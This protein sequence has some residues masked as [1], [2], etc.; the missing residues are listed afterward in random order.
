MAWRGPRVSLLPQSKCYQAGFTVL[1]LPGQ[2]KAP[3]CKMQT[4]ARQVRASRKDM[5]D[6]E[7]LG[8]HVKGRTPGHLPRGHVGQDKLQLVKQVPKLKAKRE[9]LDETAPALV[10]TSRS[11]K[12]HW[13]WG[14]GHEITAG[15]HLPASS[16]QQAVWNSAWCGW[17]PEATG[18]PE[19]LVWLISADPHTGSESAFLRA[20]ITAQSAVLHR[21]RF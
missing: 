17:F 13:F 4:S 10:A 3:V 2:W 9:R 1:L 8:K 6:G 12:G 20:I 18:Q 16:V 14:T 7:E 11:F 19:R 15:F 5:R 21:G